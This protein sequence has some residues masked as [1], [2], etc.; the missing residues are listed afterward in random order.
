MVTCGDSGAC[1]QEIH[2]KSEVTK[3]YAAVADAIAK[4]A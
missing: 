3:A 4:L 1:Y 2:A